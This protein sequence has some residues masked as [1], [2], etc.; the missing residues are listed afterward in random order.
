VTDRQTLHDGKDCA[1]QSVARVRKQQHKLPSETQTPTKTA[2]IGTKK[3]TKIL[4]EKMLNDSYDILHG[5]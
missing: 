3:T 2:T 1:M 5:Y 4:P